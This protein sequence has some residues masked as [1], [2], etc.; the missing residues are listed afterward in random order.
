MLWNSFKNLKNIQNWYNIFRL[1]GANCQHG[2][3]STHTI[4]SSKLGDLEKAICDLPQG[5]SKEEIEQVISKFQVDIGT[6]SMAEQ[7]E[8][9]EKYFAKPESLVSLLANLEASEGE[10]EQK[11]AKKLRKM[12]P[13]SCAITFKQITDGASMSFED[14]FKMEY[15]LG[16]SLISFESQ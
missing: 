13:A 7:L 5:I 2:G 16:K 3:V 8:N 12:S 10:W 9:I 6:F 14:I 4:E 11:I 15:R 1:H